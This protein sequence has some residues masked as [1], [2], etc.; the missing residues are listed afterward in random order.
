M[1]NPVIW[2]QQ[3]WTIFENFL[4]GSKTWRCRGASPRLCCLT[5]EVTISF[6]HFFAE[7]WA[8]FIRFWFFA[9]YLREMVEFLSLSKSQCIACTP[10]HLQTYMYVS[11]W[12]QVPRQVYR[13]LRCIIL[14]FLK[15][16]SFRL[17]TFEQILEFWGFYRERSDEGTASTVIN[18]NCEW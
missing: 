5:F 14:F 3:F 10:S 1:R 15:C 13:K 6:G 4:F 8:V 11:I 2:I 9:N 7:M 17:A 18:Y 12:Q 16:K